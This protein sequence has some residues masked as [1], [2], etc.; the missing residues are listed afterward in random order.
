MKIATLL[1]LTGTASAGTLT[2]GSGKQY[3]TIA[4]A[5]A[6][7]QNGDTIEIDAG[8]YHET[9]TW[10]KDDLTVRGVGGQPIV[11][12]TGMAISNG[13][14]I[15]VSDG[16]NATF[17]NLAFVGASVGDGNGAGIRWEGEGKLTVTHCLFKSNEDGILGGNHADNVADVELSEFV[18][19]SRGD[20]GFTHSV[21][22]SEIDK[23]TFQGNWSHALYAGGSDVGH[24]FKSRAKHN[25]V[26]YNRL[27]AEDNPSSYEVNIPEGGEAYVIGNLIQQKVGGQR[28]M[29]SFGDGDGTQNSGSKLYVINNTFVS[30]YADDATFIRTTQS[31]AQLY[32]ANNLIVGPGQMTQ[33]G[34]G[35]FGFNLM[36]ASPQFVNQ[37]AYD[38]HLASGS[39]AIDV[40]MTVTDTGSIALVATSQYKHPTA[41]EA[42]GANGPIDVGAYEFGNAPIDTTD[43]TAPVG[44]D[45]TP[46]STTDD[47]HGG[48]CQ[49]GGGQGSVVLA[50]GTL[51]VLRRRKR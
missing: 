31:D 7:A 39:P 10:A 26:L 6:A 46:T 51:L 47:D 33:G 34:M 45:D 18:D 43:G 24:L 28:I 30:E 29:I 14:G 41:T 22:F 40:G 38:Y 21:Y 49:T 8:T 23:V 32:V 50:L 25:F 35:H 48:C 12:M 4:A 3:T 5:A 44:G 2:V 27:T 15:F 11:D 16:N 42:R 37:A 36:T 9:V 20:A 13:K 1:L 19:N 17:D